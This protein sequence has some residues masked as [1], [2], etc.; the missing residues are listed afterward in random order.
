MWTKMSVANFQYARK[1]LNATHSNIQTTAWETSVV[2]L[3]EANWKE[4][5]LKGVWQFWKLI[6]E[7]IKKMLKRT[8]LS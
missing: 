6:S 4:N 3:K 2:V 5:D 8:E 7:I 1:S